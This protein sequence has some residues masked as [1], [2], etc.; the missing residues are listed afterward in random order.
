MKPPVCFADRVHMM[1]P[2]LTTLCRS[3]AV[4]GA[5]LKTDQHARVTCR[6]CLEL[7]AK[8]DR[9]GAAENGGLGKR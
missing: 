9:R 6:K 1:T 8:A 5:L 2:N 7:L 3:F 4:Q